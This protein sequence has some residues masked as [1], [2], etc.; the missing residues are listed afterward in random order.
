MGAREVMLTRSLRVEG[1][2]TVPSRWLLRLDGLL[3]TLGLDP[4]RLQD[5]RWLD[6]QMK[7][8]RPVRVTPSEP[9]EPRPPVA[10]RPR[11]L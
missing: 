2:P 7:L 1:T 9:P 4:E 10:K 5:G 6:W 8:D 3:R 11:R